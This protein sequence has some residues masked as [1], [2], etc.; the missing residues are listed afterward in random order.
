MIKELF[1]FIVKW[2]GTK[3]VAE[4]KEVILDYEKENIKA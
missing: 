3:G 1:Y 4:L 2:F